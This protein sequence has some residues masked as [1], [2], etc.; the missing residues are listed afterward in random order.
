MDCAWR[1]ACQ[2]GSMAVWY[3]QRGRGLG[4]GRRTFSTLPATDTSVPRLV[5]SRW[6]AERVTERIEYGAPSTSNRASR[7]CQTHGERPEQGRCPPAE[8]LC[9]PG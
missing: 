1:M 3:F 7:D 9:D 8:S 6:D 4:Q 5:Y 2:H